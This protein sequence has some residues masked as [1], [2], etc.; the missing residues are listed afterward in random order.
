MSEWMSESR[1][2]ADEESRLVVREGCNQVSPLEAVQHPFTV[3]TD[4]SRELLGA[5]PPLPREVHRAGEELVLVSVCHP[6]SLNRTWLRT[7]S[8]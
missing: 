8:P 7:A 3:A 2:L 1:S 4:P 5:R 6:L